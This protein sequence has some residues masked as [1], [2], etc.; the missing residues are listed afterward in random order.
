MRLSPHLTSPNLRWVNK[1]ADDGQS[2]NVLS[3]S[4]AWCLVL[5]MQMSIWGRRRLVY[6]AGFLEV[7]ASE[8]TLA[9]T[10]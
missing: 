3:K 9:A 1:T 2:G 5:G 4:A 8:A 7:E 10:P 6:H